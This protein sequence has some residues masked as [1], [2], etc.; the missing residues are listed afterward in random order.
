MIFNLT[1]KS[2]LNR[3]TAFLLSV[4]SIAISVVLLLGIQRIVKA[5][6]VH[7]LNTINETDMIVGASNGSIDIMLNL[8]FHIGDGLTEV[9]YSSFEDISKFDEIK[10]SVPL[11]V[12]D[13]FRGFDAVST[14]AD[15]F[16]HYKYSS[17]KLLEF[18]HGG[19]FERF[20]DLILGS[21]VAKKLNLQLGDKAYLSHGSSHH[22]HKNREFKV[23]GIL[24]KSSTPNDDLVF[25]Q[26]KTDEAMHLEWQ[27]GHFVDMHISSEALSHMN[28]KPK[29]ISG[30]LL[31]L[32]NTRQILEVE[33]KI[34]HY[35]GENLKAVIPAKAL[36]KLYKLMK[37]L[38]DV[39]MFISSM[40]FVGAIFTMLSS[41]FST[42]GEKRREIAILRSL[43]AGV[44][45]I[46]TLFVMESFFI[47]LG[48][49]ILGNLL[50][51]IF[52]FFAKTSI[53]ISYFP[54]M[55]ELFIL[56][57]MMFVAVSASVV[58]AIKSYRYSL[59]DGLMV[60]V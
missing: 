4:F 5:S 9:H 28:I 16:K 54:D 23:T 44:K 41:M 20:Y 2:I 6:K 11:S 10:W 45:V 47:V 14:N 30:M 51:S 59:Q 57:V 58:P 48:G 1:Y 32:K 46:F 56:L 25:M 52:V 43:G 35:K 31:G 33:D 49:I 50:L 22:L 37:N 27:S 55:Y 34:N 7:F 12:G 29:H 53:P 8:I 39:L 42:L 26:L 40:V 36:T 13:S 15:F 3:K 17:G 38:Q 60:K 24:K 19:N 21:N 18:E